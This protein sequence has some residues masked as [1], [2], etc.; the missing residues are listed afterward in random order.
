MI[1][2]SMIH[3]F[4]FLAFIAYFA[5]PYGNLSDPFEGKLTTLMK[6]LESS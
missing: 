4:V 6:L 5:N 1:G 3:I 2:P